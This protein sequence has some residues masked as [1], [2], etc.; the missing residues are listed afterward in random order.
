MVPEWNLPEIDASNIW[1]IAEFDSSCFGWDRRRLLEA[2]IFSE[3]NFGYFVSEQGRI[4]GYVVAKVCDDMAE[5]GPLVC[6]G[7]RLDIADKLLRSVLERLS[8]LRVNVCLP[9]KAISLIAELSQLGFVEDFYVTRNVS[10]QT[11]SAKLYIPR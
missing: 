2:L 4:A 10:R 3:D 6:R 1:E 8:G 11:C 9:K 5:V 7:N